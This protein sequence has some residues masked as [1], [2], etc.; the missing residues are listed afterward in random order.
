MANQEQKK[1][2]GKV[3]M[4]LLDPYALEQLAQVLTFGAEKYEANGWRKGIAWMRTVGALLRHTFAF[5]QGQTYDPE[6]GLHH[7]AHVMCNAMFLVNWS[8]THPE[9]DDRPT[10]E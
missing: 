5:M 4:D 7:M 3:R 1:D 8:E 10:Q 6:T 9:L 2:A